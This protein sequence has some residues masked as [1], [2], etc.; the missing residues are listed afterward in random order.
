MKLK[1]LILPAL[2]LLI[3]SWSTVPV[4][5]QDDEDNANVRNEDTLYYTYMGPVLSGGYMKAAYTD[6]FDAE[7]VTREEK[8]SGVYYSGGMAICIFAGE[9]CGDFQL[10]YVYNSLD[11]SLAFTEFSISGKYLYP[12]NDIFSAGGGLGIYFATPPSNMH[13]D[14]SAGIMLPLSAVFNTTAS[15]KAFI[16]IYFGYGS[17]GIGEETSSLKAG[18][19]AGFVFK[20]GRI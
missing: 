12:F 11:Y 10:K 2:A 19:N 1:K 14:G 6:W 4:Y 13:Y 5:S 16:D 3:F 8:V 9:F 20:V 15:T 17:F 18:I 7:T